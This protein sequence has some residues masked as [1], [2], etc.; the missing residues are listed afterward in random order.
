M[1]TGQTT[2]FESHMMKQ[3]EIKVIEKQIPW[4]YGIKIMKIITIKVSITL[5]ILMLQNLTHG[6]VF[7][8]HGS[9]MDQSI[10]LSI[11]KKEILYQQRCQEP[12]KPV[13]TWYFWLLIPKKLQQDLLRIYLNMDLL[14]MS[15]W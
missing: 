3:I 9:N 2:K 4:V 10:N 12:V 6:T 5:T 15:K 1:K 8:V 14:Q 7:Q 11:S 13:Y